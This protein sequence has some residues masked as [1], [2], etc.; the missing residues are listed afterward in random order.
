MFLAFV[1][2][3]EYFKL[4]SR[5]VANLKTSGDNPYPHK[6]HVGMSLV[7]YIDKYQNINDGTLQEETTVS[8]SGK[9]FRNL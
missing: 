9:P 4:R 3:Q 6:F 5:A 7:E 8:V 1:L 2:F